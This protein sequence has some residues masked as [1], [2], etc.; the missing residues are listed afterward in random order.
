MYHFKA[1]AKQPCNVV[2]LLR[3]PALIL[4]D[5]AWKLQTELFSADLGVTGQIGSEENWFFCF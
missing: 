4:T 5:P 2:G 1:T 3:F